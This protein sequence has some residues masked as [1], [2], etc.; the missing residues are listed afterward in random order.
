[1]S[2]RNQ[3]LVFTKI[4]TGMPVPGEHIAVKDVGF[5]LS[6]PAPENGLILETLYVSL[7]PYLRGLL[8][9]PSVKSYMPAVP[10]G[11]PISAAS[12]SKVLKSKLAGFEEG[13]IVRHMLPIQ[14][15]NV[16]VSKSDQDKPTKIDTKGLDD[17]RHYLGALG[18]PGLT[19]YSS[20]YE[21]GKPKKGET[22]VVSSAAGAVGQLVGQLAKHEGLKVLGSVGSD[23]KLEFITKEL[24]FDGGWNYKKEK[25]TKDAIERLTDGKGIDIFYDNVGGEQLEGA[26]E[27]LNLF[28]RIVE[29]GQISQYNLPPDQRYG[30][31]NLFQ[32]VAKR[33]T[34][35]GFM[36]AD[37]N[38]G[39]RHVKDHQENVKKWLKDGSFKAKIHE[40]V[41]MENAGEAFVGMLKGDNFGKAILKVK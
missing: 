17:I 27:S 16:C 33:L 14:E 26:I 29:C 19:A 39:P 3:A 1:M 25:S 22:I 9:D 31:S 7:D 21:I 2:T 10:V 35:T 5:D 28:G 37:A 8:R 34:M 15:Y 12:L 23:D 13:E 24:G 6:Q 4:P 18:M 11:T 38:M 32:T 30:I 36:V 40:T 20:L 41:G